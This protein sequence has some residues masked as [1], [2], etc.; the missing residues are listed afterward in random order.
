MLRLSNYVIDLGIA[1]GEQGGQLLFADKIHNISS[2]K[3]AT[4]DILT[5]KTPM[6]SPV[7]PPNICEW[8]PFEHVTANNLHDISATL[9][10]GRYTVIC[11]VSGSGKSTFLNRGI[12]RLAHRDSGK[13]GFNEIIYLAQTGNSSNPN[14]TVS[15]LL[16]LGKK[17]A[18]KFAALSSFEEGCFMLHSTKGKCEN[19]HGKGVIC[20]EAGELLG[21]CEECQG[22]RFNNEILS[23]LYSGKNIYDVLNTPLKNLG[24]IFCESFYKEISITTEMLGVGHLSLARQANTLSKGEWQRIKLAQI[25]YENKKDSLYLFDEPSK[26]LHIADAQKLLRGIRQLTKNC[27]T[28]ICVEHNPKMIQGS[29]YVIEFNRNEEGYGFIAHAGHVSTLKDTPT[30]QMLKVD[31]RKSQLGIPMEEKYILAPLKIHADDFTL[32]LSRNAVHHVEQN[33]DVVSFASKK[34]LSDFYSLAM[35][36]NP[37][38]SRL[39]D[40]DVRVESP[41]FLNID[42]S[43][44][45]LSSQSLYSLLGVERIAILQLLE[46]YNSRQDFFQYILNHDSPSGKCS[47]CKGSG[48][49]LS[50]NESYFIDDGALSKSCIKFLK[51]NKEYKLLKENYLSAYGINVEKSI[52]ELPEIARQILFMGGLIRNNQQWKGIVPLFF[53]AHKF[54]QKDEAK[55]ILASKSLCVCPEC[56]GE[57][58][59]PAFRHF[60]ISGVPYASFLDLPIDVLLERLQKDNSEKN[61]RIHTILDIACILGLGK[62]NLAKQICS[63]SA[64][65]SGLAQLV[66]LAE[67]RNRD[68]AIAIKGEECIPTCLR[69]EVMR[70]VENLANHNCTILLC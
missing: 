12:L 55:R 65:E 19:C 63:L 36:N 39:L 25:L 17:V 28:V 4:T 62:H 54:Y 27:N 5:E 46:T 50:L 68:L 35:P 33:S 69:E 34:N 60:T 42:F 8:I 29:D 6:E 3:T 22:Q 7:T 13:Y 24:E 26:G 64:V 11:G 56:Q 66:S 18:K 15:S 40:C 31:S 32:E 70:I 61:R 67:D 14:S 51:G 57:R 23:V 2:Y 43:A 59:E 37:I 52:K 10:R 9:P 1:G 45:S 21:C 41:P 53:K 20:T 38:Y 48:S 49:I 44:K 58:L 30:A 47:L 16:D